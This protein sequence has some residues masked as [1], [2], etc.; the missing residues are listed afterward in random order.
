MSASI[1]IETPL[2]DD[3]RELVA[4]LNEWALTQTPRTEAFRY[5]MAT[6]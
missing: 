2:Q 4:A 6:T 5:T 1:A 3:V